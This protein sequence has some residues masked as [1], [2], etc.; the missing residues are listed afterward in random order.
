MP[1]RLIAVV[2][3]EQMLDAQ[4]PET[5]GTNLIARGSHW[6]GMAMACGQAVYDWRMASCHAPI[7]GIENWTICADPGNAAKL[8]ERGF[9]VAGSAGE[10]LW[11]ADGHLCVIASDTWDDEGILDLIPWC[12]T[13]EIIGDPNGTGHWIHGFMHLFTESARSSRDP[14]KWHRNRDPDLALH[15]RCAAESY[16]QADIAMA[17]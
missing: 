6:R 17:S 16:A 15:R 10:I 8:Q 14:V 9:L 1:Q 4:H 12:D 3:I 11:R 7:D 2:T 13:L 5:H